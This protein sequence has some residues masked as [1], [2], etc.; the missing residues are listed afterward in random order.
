VRV[1]EYGVTEQ[2]GY[3]CTHHI[4]VR[5]LVLDPAFIPVRR[6]AQELAR[7]LDSIAMVG[8]SRLPRSSPILALWEYF[9]STSLIQGAGPIA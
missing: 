9:K 5:R 4:P 8:V 7:T 2:C 6:S 1:C 3:E